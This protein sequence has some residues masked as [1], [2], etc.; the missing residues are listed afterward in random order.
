MTRR[1]RSKAAAT[2]S[3]ADHQ[4]PPRHSPKALPD[5]NRAVPSSLSELP[6]DPILFAV[7][8][9][10]SWLVAALLGAVVLAAAW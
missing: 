1:R 9:K 7:K 8:D 4:L 10:T 2:G 5:D 6:D 3:G